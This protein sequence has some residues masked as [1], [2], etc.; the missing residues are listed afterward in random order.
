MRRK[1]IMLIG[2]QKSG[3]TTLAALL[4][5]RE[6]AI[7]R[8]PNM[9]YREKTLDTPGAYLE[10]PWMHKH[11]IA[12][13]QDACCVVMAADAAEKK[14]AYPPAF[15]KAFRVPVIGVVTRCD[16][17]DANPESARR[18]LLEAGVKEPVLLLSIREAESVQA[19]LQ[20]LAPHMPPVNETQRPE[21]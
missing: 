3:K 1:R 14:R 12:A 15:A 8:V 2:P 7:R 5:G 9:V 19:F 11:L 10:S 17:P 18:Q 21:E 16:L 20:T 6:M 13:A 4:E